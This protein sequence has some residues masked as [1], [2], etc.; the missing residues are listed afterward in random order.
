MYVRN[1]PR[2]AAVCLTI[3]LS[4]LA[5]GAST[6]LGTC[7]PF[8]DTAADAFCPFVLELFTL[9][10][11]TGTT[12]TTYDPSASVSR[13]AMAAFLS[14]SVDAALKRGSKRA[15]LDQFWTNPPL[16]F[17]TVGPSPVGIKS[18]G[19][20]VWVADSSDGTV[21]RVRGSDLKVLDTW[22]GAANARG[23]LPVAG[24]AL[25]S[26]A[27]SSGGP[28][29][30][31]IIDPLQPPGAVTVIASN[32][33]NVARGLATD[34]RR[35]WTANNGSVSIVTPTDTLPWTVTTVTTGFGTV[36][37]PT[38]DGS[39]IW[40]TNINL[41]TL[42]K[43]DSTGGILQTV[44]VGSGPGFPLYD[45]T[46]LW[47]PTTGT[48]SVVRPGSGAVL[49][50]LTGNGLGN[51]LAAAFDGQRVLVTSVDTT[52]VSLWKADDLTPLGS[53]DLG[54]IPNRICSDGTYFWTSLT[55]A[56]QIVRF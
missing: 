7:G 12:A 38:F 15:A 27:I 44:T 9:G 35:A 54:D 28:G 11:T 29:Q 26:G 3:A 34:G 40:V 37:G 6:I 2:W 46:N 52:F 47:V 13:L 22:T 24:K 23:V 25:V 8:T 18:D 1:T 39:N 48:V 45:G 21:R 14:R 51:G 4:I 17:T 43:L 53:F 36:A 16:G 56:G 19:T 41:G 5:G 30:L 50:T 20:D 49:A 10:I 42:L 33:G 32:L 55:A 31:Y